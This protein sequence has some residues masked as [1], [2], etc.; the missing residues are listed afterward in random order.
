M[1]E[2]EESPGS[3][4]MDTTCSEAN[5]S[6]ERRSGDAD[7]YDPASVAAQ[8][9]G[10]EVSQ[11]AGGA[12]QAASD[13]KGPSGIT[14][15]RGDCSVMEDEDGSGDVEE[16]FVDEV[17]SA[18][19][20][21]SLQ[22]MVVTTRLVTSSME[23]VDFRNMSEE[24]LQS[25]RDSVVEKAKDCEALRRIVAAALIDC[26]TVGQSGTDP[27]LVIEVTGVLM[28][29]GFSATQDAERLTFEAMQV[30]TTLVVGEDEPDGRLWECAAIDRAIAC[31]VEAPNTAKLG[32]VLNVENSMANVLHGI[33]QL[34]MIK[35]PED[36]G[37]AERERYTPGKPVFLSERRFVNPNGTSEVLYSIVRGNLELEEHHFQK[38]PQLRAIVKRYREG[39]GKTLIGEAIVPSTGSFVSYV[40]TTTCNTS[41]MP[42]G[43]VFTFTPLFEA[44]DVDS[45]GP[46]YP[47]LENVADVSI[48]S[49]PQG[50]G[51]RLRSLTEL[52]TGFYAPDEKLQNFVNETFGVN[53]SPFTGAQTTDLTYYGGGE[54]FKRL[55][56][57][58]E[59]QWSAGSA[60]DVQ[61]QDVERYMA[62]ISV[63]KQDRKQGDDPDAAELTRA[64]HDEM[65]HIAIP[66]NATLLEF[67][68]YLQ[69][70]MKI[71]INK[72]KRLRF[73][74]GIMVDECAN[75]TCLYNTE[76]CPFFDPKAYPWVKSFTL[77]EGDYVLNEYNRELN[78]LVPAVEAIQCKKLLMVEL[79][80]WFCAQGCMPAPQVARM[81]EGH[82]AKGNDAAGKEVLLGLQEHDPRLAALL[83]GGQ[84][85]VYKRV[86]DI[87]IVALTFST[88]KEAQDYIATMR[89]S[90]VGAYVMTRRNLYAS[91]AYTLK[92]QRAVCASELF[93]LCR[94][95][96]V[97]AIGQNKYRITSPHGMITI[98][99]M[100]YKQNR[101][102]KNEKD[103]KGKP[104]NKFRRLNDDNDR[105]VFLDAKMPS[106]L[107]VYQRRLPL[108]RVGRRAAMASRSES[109]WYRISGLPR[110]K[111]DAQL[112]EELL[113]WGGLAGIIGWR[114][115]RTIFDPVMYVNVESTQEVSKVVREVFDRA[116]Y[117]LPSRN[118]PA[119]AKALNDTSDEFDPVQVMLR[120][121][122][123]QI[124][125]PQAM[126]LRYLEAYDKTPGPA[127]DPGSVY[128]TVELR[129]GA[130]EGK[131]RA[132]GRR[133][134]GSASQGQSGGDR[135]TG[136][137]SGDVP[138][139][140]AEKPSS[141][142]NANV[143]R[144]GSRAGKQNDKPKAVP[145]TRAQTNRAKPDRNAVEKSG[146]DDGAGGVKRKRSRKRGSAAVD[147][148]TQSHVEAPEH[149][150][151]K[152]HGPA[153]PTHSDLV[154]ASDI[155]PAHHTGKNKVAKQR[156]ISY[157]A[158]RRN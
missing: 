29:R 121:G 18:L 94:A 99:R 62:K 116:F 50:G 69:K 30:V 35:I 37:K 122:V 96:E 124:F 158:V 115:D 6:T 11:T 19:N 128:R 120:P 97:M 33:N 151:G 112:R 130:R 60:L 146:R 154:R 80:S 14:G 25:F 140:K 92:C 148:T 81:P 42:P 48:V 71:A 84:A 144:S 76:H 54:L 155:I 20:T 147:L 57:A 8:P 74:V 16:S 108:G 23:K 90:E 135:K 44:A 66:T 104:L 119:T 41:S 139:R 127:P 145:E 75:T 101:Y 49:K 110:N 4:D 65:I 91:H 95:V 82:R 59:G 7:D 77:V 22:N 15:D 70:Q 141:S 86:D 129:S 157:F 21:L 142:T 138:D 105:F 123:A 45:L 114:I 40:A 34:A 36:A 136:A 87:V 3:G 68:K 58:R 53:A 78:E 98:A 52:V 118:P 17:A 51:S 26:V 61:L 137:R 27:D 28:S 89:T 125:V 109:P 103:A 55:L 152:R 150:P 107:S 133:A 43:T 79:D 83:R 5:V 93:Q 64:M 85:S 1:P 143:D 46:V 156:L 102:K 117:V 13:E 88:E 72:G 113:R 56:A 2:Q 132:S 38:M 149:A 153:R 111:T 24:D 10:T 47:K 134:A 106:V 12:V 100:L 9:G 131:R 32:Y 73:Y 39:M 63:Y 31:K 126:T 67:A